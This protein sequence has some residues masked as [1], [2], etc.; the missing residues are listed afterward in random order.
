MSINPDEAEN[1]AKS[2]DAKIV[3]DKPKTK[4]EQERE[5]EERITVNKRRAPVR[6][7][8]MEDSK[9]ETIQIQ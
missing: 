9:T 8:K 4:E 6:P 5:D 2:M 1:S 3:R 7:R